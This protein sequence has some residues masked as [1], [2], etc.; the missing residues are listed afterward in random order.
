MRKILLS[1]TGVSDDEY[2]LIE[3]AEDTY[4]PDETRSNFNDTVPGLVD[5]SSFIF[6]F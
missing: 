1:S 6:F 5:V 2:Q 3:L 4:I